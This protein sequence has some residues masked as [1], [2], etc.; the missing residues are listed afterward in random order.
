[1]SANFETLFEE[2][3]K[4]GLLHAPSASINKCSCGEQYFTHGNVM[5]EPSNDEWDEVITEHSASK[6][7]CA[8]VELLEKEKEEE[9]NE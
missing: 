1:M 7:A 2:I 9:N 4:V 6:I 5:H 3:K 8:L